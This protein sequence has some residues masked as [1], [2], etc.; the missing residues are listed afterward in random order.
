LKFGKVV[1]ILSVFGLKTFT[2]NSQRF[3]DLQVTVA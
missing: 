3:F 2:K 1:K